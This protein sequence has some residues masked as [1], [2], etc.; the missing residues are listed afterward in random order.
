MV[1]SVQFSSK[2]FVSSQNNIGNFGKRHAMV[3]VVIHTFLAA[4]FTATITYMTSDSLKKLSGR[5]VTN[6][7]SY[8]DIVNISLEFKFFLQKFSKFVQKR[9]EI[10]LKIG[11]FS[12]PDK[13]TH[14]EW[15]CVVCIGYIWTAFVLK[16]DVPSILN[17]SLRTRSS[18]FSRPFF[19]Y[20][21]RHFFKLKCLN[22]L[23]RTGVF[24]V[25]KIVLGSIGML[26]PNA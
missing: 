10:F 8:L 18:L 25:L 26:C 11:R 15:L 1:I 3:R 16:T 20:A 22:V 6:K 19:N 9:P 14:N 12:L 4:T 17:C 13:N 21:K 7:R 23:L 24:V 5:S 2:G